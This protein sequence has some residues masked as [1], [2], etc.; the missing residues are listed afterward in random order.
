MSQDP[1]G[2]LD[3]KALTS[4]TAKVWWAL[5]RFGFRLLY[6]EL[7]WTYGLVSWGVSLGQWR[8]W[9]RTATQHLGASDGAR[10][11]EIAHGT[12]NLCL[13]MLDEGLEPVG[14][15]LSPYMGRIAARKLRRRGAPLRLVR[16]NGLQ[17]PFADGCFDAAV[18]TFPTEF[19]VARETL[20][21]VHRTLKSG[22]RMVL[23]PNARLALTNPLARL[24]EWLYRIT[25]QR[26]PWPVDVQRVFEEAGFEVQSVTEE[27]PGSQVWI[28][29]ATR[30]EF[31][32]EVAS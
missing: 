12:G 20:R 4:P 13:D 24:L 29:I 23:V 30:R 16:A 26:G 6:N 14:L 28:V 27:L 21:E 11:L 8:A 17:M 7:A 19:I 32:R 9:Q 5:I 31:D 10:V 3:T 22:A 25:G 15:D 1:A 2:S 18:S